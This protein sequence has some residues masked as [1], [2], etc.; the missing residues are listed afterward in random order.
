MRYRLNEADIVV[1]D[2]WKDMSINTFVLPAGSQG[3]ALSLTVTRDHD[4]PNLDLTSYTDQ[5]LILAAKKLP[6]YKYISRQG[7]YVGGQ[8][9]VQADYAW[10]TPE[11]KNIHQRQAV[12]KVGPTFLVFTLTAMAQDVQNIELFW[13]QTI[14]AVQLAQGA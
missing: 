11:G 2:G 9:A 12:F 13:Q 4:S 1:P 6:H 3:N 10:R 8:V 5:Q 7:A 14:G